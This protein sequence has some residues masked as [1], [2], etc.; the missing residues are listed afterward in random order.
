MRCWPVVLLLVTALPRVAQ[1]QP[2]E[3][4]VVQTVQRFFDAMAARDTAAMAAVV[5]P[6]GRYFSVLDTDEGRQIGGGLNADFLT[7]LATT[8]QHFLE[9]MWEPRVLIHGGIAVLWTEYDFHRGSDFSH[10]GV[11]AFSLV[12][13]DDGWKVAAIVYTVEPTGCEPS[14]LGSPDQQSAHRPTGNRPLLSL[15]R[16]AGSHELGGASV[17]GGEPAQPA[18]IVR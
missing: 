18:A 11:D 2:E 8:D 4:A 1:A 13:T 5:I 3:D 6:E 15:R 9:R 10:C 17:R 14:P 16:A 12:R 7:L